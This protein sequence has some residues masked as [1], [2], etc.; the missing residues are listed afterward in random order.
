MIME[1]PNF[2][3]NRLYRKARKQA[4]EI[5]AFYINLFCYFLVIPILAIV[6]FTLT[7]EVYW[8]Q[9]SAMGWGI[10]VLFHGLGV[11][12]DSFFLNH[13]WEEKKIAEYME[14]NKETTQQQPY[15]METT[16]NF[17]QLRYERARKRVKDMA[18]FYKHLSIYLVVNFILIGLKY[19]NTDEKHFLAFN[20]FSTACFWGIGLL[21]H[22][23]GVFGAGI[24]LGNNWEERKIK[25]IMDRE[26]GQDWE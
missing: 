8:V 25:E 24:F 20:T 26:K 13:S 5:R 1:S 7:P 6:N 19:F 9:F 15:A 10:G 21:F 12:K 3:N 17:D 11:Y 18:G 16:D 4:R 14:K 23:L 2:E 22:G